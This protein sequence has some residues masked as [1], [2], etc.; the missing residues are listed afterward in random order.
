MLQDSHYEK[1]GSVAVNGGLRYV[2]RPGGFIRA[3]TGWMAGDLLSR[4]K[5]QA[6]GSLL[7]RALVYQRSYIMG[8]IHCIYPARGVR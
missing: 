2:Y 1:G 3:C 4:D 5:L 8:V 6:N 7:F